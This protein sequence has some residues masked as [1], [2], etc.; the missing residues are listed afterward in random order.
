MESNKQ[1]K[2]NPKEKFEISPWQFMQFMEPLGVTDS[3][4]E[5]AWDHRYNKWFDCVIETTKELAPKLMRWGGIL[6]S[7]TRWRETVGP[8]DQRVPMLNLLWGGIETNQIGVAEFCEFCETVGADKLYCVNFLSEGKDAWA[9]TPA[10]D[11]RCADEK[12]AAEWLDYCNNPD[13]KLRISHGRKKPYDVKLWQVGNETSYDFRGNGFTCEQAAEHTIEYSNAMR[14]VD[15]DIQLIGWGDSGW[16]P[17]MLEIAG[18][19]IEYIAFHQGFGSGLEPPFIKDN[20]YRKDWD[21]TWEHLMHA[22]TLTEKKLGEMRQQISGYSQKLAMTESHFSFPGRNRNEV[23]SS[24]G[25]G[26]ANARILNVHERNGDILGIATLADFCGTRWMNNAVYIQHPHKTAHMMPVG[27][28]MSLFSKHIGERALDVTI[29]HKDLDVTASRSGNKIF[30]H[31][32]N[33]NKN[34]AATVGFDIEGTKIASGKVFELCQDPE[35]E[36]MHTNYHEL[37]VKEKDVQDLG[38]WCFPAA[39]VSAVELIIE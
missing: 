32:V 28:V 16:A 39:S 19:H 24:W 5:A 23:L 26:V 13:N 4:V 33:T 9:K 2:V 31:V 25:A 8:R 18:E 36:I 29:S 30:L 1:I 20:D 38:S 22:Y 34:N 10:G 35:W 21:K 27:Y 7:Y 17:K 37:T 11:D 14:N 12:E 6:S 3:S 15:P